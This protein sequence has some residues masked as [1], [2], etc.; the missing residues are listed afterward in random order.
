MR[1]EAQISE[2]R[3]KLEAQIAALAAKEVMFE[4]RHRQLQENMKHFVKA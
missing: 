2:Q 4:E 1:A 3:A